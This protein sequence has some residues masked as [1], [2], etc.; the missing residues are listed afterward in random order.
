MDVKRN[1]VEHV[2]ALPNEK[3]ILEWHYVVEGPPGSLYAGGFYHGILRFPKEYPYKPPTI[4]MLTR[5]GRFMVNT[6]LCL[7][8]SDFHPEQVCF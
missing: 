6:R 4:L 3:N 7:S 2:K 5:N 1:P 8:M